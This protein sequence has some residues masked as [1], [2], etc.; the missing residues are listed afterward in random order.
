MLAGGFNRRMLNRRETTA[1]AS[2]SAA[3]DVKESR[4]CQRADIS[5]SAIQTVADAAN[6]AVTGWLRMTLRP[7][8]IM[9]IAAANAIRPSQRTVFPIAIGEKDWSAERSIAD[10][11]IAWAA[12]RR[13]LL[14]SCHLLRPIRDAQASID[15]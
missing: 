4:N 11:R 12:S 9:M 6:Q 13:R 8:P 5:S 10:D 14:G 15:G 2:A 1:V 3:I 7:Q